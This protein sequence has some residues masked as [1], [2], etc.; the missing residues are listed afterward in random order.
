MRF[1]LLARRMFLAPVLSLALAA[2]IA[3]CGS[4]SSSSASHTPGDRKTGQ[5]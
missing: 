2:A 1:R 5:P 4:S 3:A